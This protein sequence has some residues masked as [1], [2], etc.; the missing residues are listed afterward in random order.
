VYAVLSA[1]QV[2][3]IIANGA[4]VDTS[5]W[6]SDPEIT[7]GSVSLGADDTLTLTTKVPFSSRNNLQMSLNGSIEYLNMTI[8]NGDGKETDSVS[9]NA[10]DPKYKGPIKLGKPGKDGFYS[11]L[12]NLASL[13]GGPPSK[14]QDTP[15]CS[16][17][18]TNVDEEPNSV[19]DFV[20][21]SATLTGSS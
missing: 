2:N 6:S 4:V 18:F 1:V 7:D 14:P 3:T 13:T 12:V 21:A 19:V 16:I 15:W 8:S 20:I 17:L 5:L 10:T 9:L 11:L